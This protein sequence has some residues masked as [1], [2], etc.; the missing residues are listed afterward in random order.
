M[1]AAG[2]VVA[3]VASAPRGQYASWLPA[4]TS[5]GPSML[6]RLGCFQLGTLIGGG[7]RDRARR[8]NRGQ[9]C[10]GLAASGGG[11][12]HGRPERVAGQRD[13]GG[14]RQGAVQVGNG[15]ANVDALAAALVPGTLGGADP[16]E[17]ET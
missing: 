8:G 12:S 13:P 14:P 11:G 10:Q 15:R 5:N 17:V 6:S 2:M 16:A 9:P 4:T 3:R 7:V 1:V